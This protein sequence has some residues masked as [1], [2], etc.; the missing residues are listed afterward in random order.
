MK[1]LDFNLVVRDA[2]EAANQAGDQYIL[3]YPTWNRDLFGSCFV[4][5]KG[6][7]NGLKS[8]LKQNVPA[9]GGRDEL[10]RFN[11]F[12]KYRGVQQIGINCECASAFMASLENAGIEGLELQE[13]MN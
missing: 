7:G 11:R 8:W 4:K 12:I 3:D 9:M 1:K 10:I 5:I 13:W 2:I 6:N